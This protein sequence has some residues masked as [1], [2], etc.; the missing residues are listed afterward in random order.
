MKAFLN[1]RRDADVTEAMASSKS[2]LGSVAHIGTGVIFGLESLCLGAVSSQ[3]G[4]KSTKEKR[5]L[6]R[7]ESENLGHVRGHGDF[8]K[9]LLEGSQDLC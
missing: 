4:Q 2:H 7:T 6:Q 9:S 1:S 3:P 8:P 5:R